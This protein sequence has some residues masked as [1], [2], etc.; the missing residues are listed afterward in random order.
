MKGLI[1]EFINKPRK[2]LMTVLGNE[3]ATTGEAADLTH[4]AAQGITKNNKGGEVVVQ[5]TFLATR[6]VQE[7]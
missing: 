4:V 6:P 7:Q 1:D 5:S 2:G 3:K